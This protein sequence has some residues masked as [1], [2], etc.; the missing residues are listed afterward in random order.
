MYKKRG[1]GTILRLLGLVVVGLVVG[2]GAVLVLVPGTVGTVFGS[3]V[4]TAVGSTVG[5][6]VGST[7][8][9]GVGLAEPAKGTCGQSFALACSAR[10]VTA[11]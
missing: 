7:V 6:D 2:T 4:G 9:T 10:R 11:L 8:G 3:L 1:Q 5:I